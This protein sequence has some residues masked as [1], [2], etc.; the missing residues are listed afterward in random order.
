M[1]R[2][3]KGAILLCGIP[4]SGKTQSGRLL[5]ETL[6]IPFYDLDE[7]LTRRVGKSITGIFATEG[8]K[9]F[10]QREVDCLYDL[11]CDST[12][13]IIALGGGTLESEE[14]RTLISE[15]HSVLIWLQVDSTEAAG[16]LEAG[17]QV[18]KH[19]LLKGLRGE[20]LSDKLREFLNIRKVNYSQCEFEINTD[21]LN[22]I[23]VAQRVAEMLAE[24]HLAD[25]LHNK[26]LKH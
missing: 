9:G 11:M 23:Q 4:G 18:D 12:H 3:D 20:M 26:D 24:Y 15:Y 1:K 5:A 6:G 2:H 10:R 7:E 17:G 13:K 14:A 25:P 22:D 19:P 16:R 8:E 21:G